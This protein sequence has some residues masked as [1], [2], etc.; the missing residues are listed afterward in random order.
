MKIPCLTLAG[1]LAISLAGAPM[2]DA[3]AAP[4]SKHHVARKAGSKKTQGGVTVESQ[5]LNGDGTPDTVVASPPKP[6]PKK[7]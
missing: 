6:K 7:H 4:K 3:I 5:D 2:A 1:L